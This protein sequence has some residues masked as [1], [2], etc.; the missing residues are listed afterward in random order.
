[1]FVLAGFALGIG[2][3]IFGLMYVA[4]IADLASKK[5]RE[6]RTKEAELQNTRP[7]SIHE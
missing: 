3:A 6:L 2:I 1:M 5:S 7:K 4:R